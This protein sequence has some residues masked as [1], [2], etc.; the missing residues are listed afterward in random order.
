MIGKGVALNRL[1]FNSPGVAG[2]IK[3]GILR[4]MNDLG[5]LNIDKLVGV[6]ADKY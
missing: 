5:T 2:K 4:R 1:G 6:W 3:R